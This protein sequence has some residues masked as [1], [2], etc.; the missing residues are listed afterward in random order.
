MDDEEQQVKD[1]KEAVDFWKQESF[2]ALELDDLAY[3]KEAQ[4]NM[5]RE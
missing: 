4:T 1:L 2:A 5:K 3:F